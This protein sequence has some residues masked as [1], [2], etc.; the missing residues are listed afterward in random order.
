MLVQLREITH[1][2]K[3]VSAT[4][5]SSDLISSQSAMAAEERDNH[6]WSWLLESLS[7]DRFRQMTAN[8]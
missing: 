2:C 8:L 1:S 7:E 3:P 5:L 6:L 4:A